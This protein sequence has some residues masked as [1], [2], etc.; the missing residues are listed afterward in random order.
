[1]TL[2]FYIHAAG[3]WRRN[4]KKR[5]KGLRKAWLSC[6]VPLLASFAVSFSAVGV[7]SS[8]L[9]TANKEKKYSKNMMSATLEIVFVNR[10][11]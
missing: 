11:V 4:V 8:L 9:K 7:R 6:F 10:S 5:Q 1:M 2:A 3:L